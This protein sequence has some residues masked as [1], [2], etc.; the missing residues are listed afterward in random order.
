MVIIT[1]NI[2][3]ALFCF[4]LCICD[5]FWSYPT[6]LGFFVLFPICA[7]VCEI[8]TDRSSSLQMLSMAT[9]SPLMASQAVFVSVRIIFRTLLFNSFL[10]FPSFSFFHLKSLTYYSFVVVQLLSRAQVFV[11]PWTAALQASLSFSISWSLLR[12]MSI[13]LVMPSSHLILCYP[14]LLPSVFPSIRVFAMS[15]LVASGD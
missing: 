12:L 11:T 14:L 1:S 3:S 8:Y 2:S 6:V 7:S 4:Q 13:E 5:T 15:L 9:L 10:E